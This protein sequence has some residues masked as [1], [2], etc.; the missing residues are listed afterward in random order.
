MKISLTQKILLVVAIPL[1]IQLIFLAFLSENL[2]DLSEEQNSAQRDVRAVMARDRL[3]INER[4]RILLMTMYLATL[5]SVCEYKF[6]EVCADTVIIYN[7]LAQL[8]RNSAER[9]Q[10]LTK[11]WNM[12]V[13][14][15]R[16][17]SSMFERVGRENTVNELL[18]NGFAGNRLM[19]KR[20][21]KFNKVPYIERFF[22]EDQKRKNQEDEA[23]RKRMR[24]IHSLLYIGLAALLLASLASGLLFSL[25]VSR[26]LKVVL[27]NIVALA[28]NHTELVSMKDGDEISKLNAAVIVTAHKIREAEEFQAQTIAIIAEELNKPLTEVEAALQALP[29]IGFESLTEKG[30]KRLSDSLLEVK[31]LESLVFELVNLDALGRDLHVSQL[32]LGEM[33]NKCLKIVEPLTRLKSISIDVKGF[34]NAVVYADA[35][36]TTQ[37]LINLLSNAIKYSPDKSS[38]EITISPTDEQQLRVSV[39]DNGPGISEEFH[40]RIFGR[41]EQSENAQKKAS[42]GL[43]LQISKEIIETEGGHVGFTSRLGEGATFWFSLPTQAEQSRRNA[44]SKSTG[45]PAVGGWKPTLW[46]KALLVVALPLVVQ[47][48]TV[49]SL[50][51]FL[52]QNSEKIAELEKVPR[53]TALCGQLIEGATNAGMYALIYNA[54]RDNASLTS[55]R[56]ED[57]KLKN[58]MTELQKFSAGDP[59]T[60]VLAK[61]LLA[62]INAHMAFHQHLINAPQ[63]A[64]LTTIIGERGTDKKENL[65]I[66]IRGPMHDLLLYQKDL[67]ASNA[68]ASE[69]IR[70][71]ISVLMV[72]SAVA[73]SI[74]ACALA[75]LIARSLTNRTTRLSNI[76]LQFSD[77]RE[78]P[79]PLPGDDE[80]A[81]VERQLHV[82]GMKLIELE[83]LRTE[84]IGIT[85]HELRTPLT[86][87]IALVEVMEAGVFGELTEQGQILLSRARLE[88]SELIVLITNL[89]DLEKMESG[90][91]LVTKQ[92]MN[93]E[94]VLEQLK[95]D[96]QQTAGTRGVELQI[97]DC[98]R[99]IVGDSGRLSQAL[100]AVIRSILERLPSHS[101][102]SV[103]CK[104]DRDSFTFAIIAPY[105]IS[106][107]GYSNKHRELARE[108]MAISLARQTARQHGGHL[109]LTTTNRGRTIEICLPSGG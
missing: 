83:N 72:S 95:V 96:N 81:F 16:M 40:S 103:D 87:I 30:A 34:E 54:D 99:E 35:D 22:I 18:Q 92:K 52:K 85:S 80:L 97:H 90:K 36:K 61:R 68:L 78:L 82:A 39:K 2:T 5:D 62:M 56:E 44:G 107:S 38:I 94:Q 60:D 104:A 69:D 11:V 55:A 42:S 76:A 14:R 4:Q 100:T 109:N 73:A 51:N 88:T 45:S 13:D 37:V 65:L 46:R 43:G 50:N 10:E 15:D 28:N 53:V 57:A 32:D 6:K 48:F 24:F 9:A 25:S 49:I 101:L 12:N 19:L 67:I 41:F 7:D 3:F 108:E 66:D 102:V 84:M 29:Q 75:L 59:T 23:V 71:S 105:G 86:S 98:D 21:L 1:A 20:L 17:V 31:R 27:R 93:V 79:E 8:W 63:N 47:L 74:V 77:R 89:L 91:I 106:K 70:R 64:N 33:V 26:R 58:Y